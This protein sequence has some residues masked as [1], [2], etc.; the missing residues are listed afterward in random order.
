MTYLALSQ[1]AWQ[2][3]WVVGPGSNRKN[4]PLGIWEE[5]EEGNQDTLHNLQPWDQGSPGTLLL[6]IL[7]SLGAWHRGQVWAHTWDA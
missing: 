5:P 1:A 2:E 3:Q 6:H 7:G 4:D